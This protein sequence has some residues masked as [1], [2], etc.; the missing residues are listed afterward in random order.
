MEHDTQTAYYLIV[1]AK[2]K[3]RVYKLYLIIS[4]IMLPIYSYTQG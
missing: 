2:Y 3:V 1:M 4:T